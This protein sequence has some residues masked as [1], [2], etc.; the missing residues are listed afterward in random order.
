MI[1]GAIFLFLMYYLIPTIWLLIPKF[2]K[3]NNI[4]KTIRIILL[5]MY[6][7][8]LFAI[9]FLGLIKGPNVMFSTL[10]FHIFLFPIFIYLF[11]IKL[12]FTKNKKNKEN[13]E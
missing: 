4:I 1:K 6:I 11:M 2:T 8:P 13:N 3:D 7:F 10:S 5:G 12:T 9:T